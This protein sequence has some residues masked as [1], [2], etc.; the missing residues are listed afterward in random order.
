[1]LL[2]EPSGN[3]LLAS[4]NIKD[5]WLQITI[6]N[7]IIMKKL[8]ILQELKKTWHRDTKWANALWK[9]A[10]MGLFDAGLPQISV[11]KKQSVCEVQES[12]SEQ[13]NVCH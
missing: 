11:C 8:G 3:Y 9:T 13:N 4:S 7:I 2:S 10:P 1:M 6:T 5:H 12:E